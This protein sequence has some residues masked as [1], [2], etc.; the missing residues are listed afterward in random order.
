M[1]RGL[2]S[3]H[4]HEPPVLHCD[5]KSLN[6]LVDEHWCLKLADFGESAFAFDGEQHRPRVTAQWAAPELAQ[7]HPFTAKA[8]VYSMAMCMMEIFTG[9]QPFQEVMKARDVTAMVLKGKR[10]REALERSNVPEPVKGM[11]EQSWSQHPADRPS[12]AAWVGVMERLQSTASDG[13][14]P[15]VEPLQLSVSDG[16]GDGDWD[17]MA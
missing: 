15:S 6:L 12:V 7:R 8:D 14:S 11:I 2:E 5:L 17:D 1:A 3:L 16:D 10:P 9:E 4:T 13:S